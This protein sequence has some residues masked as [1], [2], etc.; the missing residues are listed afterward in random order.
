MKTVYFHNPGEMDIRGAFII[1]LSAKEDA[2]SAIGKFGSGLKYAIASILRWNGAVSIETGGETYE[3][4]KDPIVFRGKEHD[5]IVMRKRGT[6]ELQ[7][8]GFTTHYGSHWQPWQIF[9]ELYSNARDEQGGVAKSIEATG[10]FTTDCTIIRVD[11]PKVADC[12]L[13][14]DTI[15]LPTPGVDCGYGTNLR[16]MDCPS[17]FLY[18]RGVRVAEA[19]CLATWNK[20]DGVELT[21]DRTVSSTF[22]WKCTA[23]EFVQA[24]SDYDFVWKM[25]TAQ[26]GKFEHDLQ[27][28]KWNT[29][30]STFIDAATSLYKSVGKSKLP[31]GVWSV[32]TQAKPELDAPQVVKLSRMQQG[33]LDRAITLVGKMGFESVHDTSIEVVN[34]HKDTLGMCKGSKVYLSPQVFEQGTKQVVSTLF[35]EMLHLET[36]LQDCTYEMQTRLFNMI[37]SLHEEH[38]IGEAC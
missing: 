18:Y 27:Y 8:L 23:G 13:E 24:S 30:S 7:V 22:S 14:R 9:R 10:C 11:C 4:S 6:S 33:Q 20:T 16:F 5:Q 31:S 2:D 25:L 35:E 21:E 19:K 28:C 36:G 17:N 26:K 37:I 3:F 15:L 1:G 34:F 12:Y 29:T 32:L 38:T